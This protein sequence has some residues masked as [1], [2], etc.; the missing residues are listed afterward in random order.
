MGRCRKSNVSR[1]RYSPF[2][3]LTS[4]ILYTEIRITDANFE[5]NIRFDEFYRKYLTSM[6]PGTCKLYPE[7]PTY[8]LLILHSDYHNSFSAVFLLVLV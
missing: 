1:D 2:P 6:V 8:A 3:L 5:H 4:H 7:N